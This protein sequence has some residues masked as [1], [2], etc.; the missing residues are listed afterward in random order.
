MLVSERCAWSRRAA[1]YLDVSEEKAVSLRCRGIAHEC[2]W[3]VVSDSI[4]TANEAADVDK[5]L[6]SSTLT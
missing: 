4:R 2:H 1:V 3:V 6:R 5:G